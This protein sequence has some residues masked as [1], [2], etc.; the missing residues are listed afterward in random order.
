MAI[1]RVH[2]S[3]ILPV[4]NEGQIFEANIKSIY[5]ILGK[6]K[7]SWEV[8][9]VEDKST[10]GSAEILKKNSSK[11]PN[12]KVIYHSKNLGRGKSVSDGIKAANGIYCGFLDIDLEVSSDYIPLFINE[13]EKGF[14]MVIGNRFYEKNLTAITRVLTSTGYKL[15]VRSVLNLPI[16]DTEAGYKFFRREKILP[17]LSEIADKGWFWDT[18]VCARTYWAGLKISQVP[19][20]FIRRTEKKSTV[21]LIPDTLTYLKNMY[22]FR[23]QIPKGN[24]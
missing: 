17:V 8:I 23:T 3:L 11:L 22:K 14:D 18:E 6:L 5:K 21:R 12:T 4:F 7:K 2:F 19:V 16:D 15:I 10:D 20:L 9:F 13:L 1:K 24:F